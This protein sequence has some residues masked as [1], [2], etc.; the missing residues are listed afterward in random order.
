MTTKNTE[1]RRAITEERDRATRKVVEQAAKI[2]RLQA[3]AKTAG[4]RIEQALKWRD[5][6]ILFLQDQ[7]AEQAIETASLKRQ[8]ASMQI[9]YQQ[10]LDD[11]QVEL[12]RQLTA[13]N[14]VVAVILS[15]HAGKPL[16]ATI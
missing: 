7:L 2:A 14:R 10:Q 16:H 8:I 5:N 9:E 13:E 15:D 4:D 11:L 1:E 3:E 6:R 12:N